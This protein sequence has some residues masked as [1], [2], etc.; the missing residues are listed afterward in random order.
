MPNL[1][2]VSVNGNWGQLSVVLIAV[3]AVLLPL[4]CLN[5]THCVSSR[6]GA[7]SKV[8][9]PTV[10]HSPAKA[11]TAV[12]GLWSNRR[13]D[14]RLQVLQVTDRLYAA[15]AVPPPTVSMRKGLRLWSSH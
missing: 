6:S 14:H 15:R 9:A 3:H 12:R 8:G 7:Y 11:L 13:A 5:S 2:T 10:G 1:V 4:P